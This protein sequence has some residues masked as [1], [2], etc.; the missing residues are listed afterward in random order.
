MLDTCSVLFGIAIQR[1]R[2]VFFHMQYFYARLNVTENRS[3]CVVLFMGKVATKRKI[4]SRR[5]K[6]CENKK[7]TADKKCN[8]NIMAESVCFSIE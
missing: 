7:C 3:N 1:T 5:V 2:Y 4:T 8:Y 6:T